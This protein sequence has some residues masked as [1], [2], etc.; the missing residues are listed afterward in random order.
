MFLSQVS[1]P[2]S[3]IIFQGERFDTCYFVIAP[4]AGFFKRA[5]FFLLLVYSI[6]INGPI[7]GRA[8]LDLFDFLTKTN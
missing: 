5:T 3:V 6:K 2:I 7:L 4:V 8:H 1:S